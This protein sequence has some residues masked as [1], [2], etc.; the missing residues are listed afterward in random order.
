MIDSRPEKRRSLRKTFFRRYLFFTLI[1]LAIV[2]VVVLLQY[3]KT[4]ESQIQDR[5]KAHSREVEALFAKEQGESEKFVAFSVADKKI[6]YYLTSLKSEDLKSTLR[7]KISEYA[8]KRIMAYTH[9]GQVF[10]NY[11]EGF[12]SVHGARGLPGSL[13]AE[14]ENLKQLSRVKFVRK[15]G[16]TFLNLSVI[17]AVPGLQGK[18][19]GYIEANMPLNKKRLDEIAAQT[20][21]EVFLF[22][23][24]GKV[25]VG[26][27]PIQDIEKAN[28][29]QRFLQGKNQYFE[30]AIGDTPYAL[31]ATALTWGNRQFLVGMGVDTRESQSRI[32]N[33][34]I[35]IALAFGCILLFSFIMSLFF[36]REFISPVEKITQAMDEMK[37]SRKVVYVQN[38]SQTELGE[39]VQNFNE[40]SLTIHESDSELKKQVKLLEKANN[41]I[42]RAQ[43]QLVQS[44]KL[45]SLGELV[46]GIAH[47]LNNPI[48]FIYS[49][50]EH[51]KS[52]SK[53]LIDV[54]DV[55]A[56]SGSI[57]PKFLEDIDFSYIK[58][59]LP[60]L[61][62]SCE[63]G[64]IRAKDIVIGLRNFSRME[65]GFR[66]GFDVNEGVESTLKLLKGVIS[67][68]VTIH[69]NFSELPKIY[70][71]GNQLKQVFMNIINNGIQ[72][73][74][75]GGSL[76]IV[77][78]VSMDQKS[79]EIQIIDN[80]AGIPEHIKEKI[81]DPF[82]TTKEVGEGT[83][84]GLS[85][86]YGIIQSHNG[87]LEVYSKVDE[88]SEFLI[89]LPIHGD[90]EG[91]IV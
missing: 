25:L 20:G 8:Q 22:N 65:D 55:A 68:S 26:T 52:Y 16:E 63:E 28:L 77:T 32:R 27:L 83:G 72:A 89:R 56:Q 29:G 17:E 75:G 71:N 70:A 23:K 73:L 6:I 91:E 53:S 36:L 80:G 13:M 38:D 4:I 58:E 12:R 31:A 42:K 78:D 81:F 64:A 37:K 86:S 82:F 47:E 45:A 54:L 30:D 67:S 33:V 62:R 18:T 79:V 50:M 3:K 34:S 21:A 41:K 44:A 61:V 7:G 1:P 2:A 66:E 9:G 88:G 11:N 14:L 69:K 84:L 24:S 48:G 90:N 57:E 46:A 5:L 60:K 19:V 51:L 59:D 74:P 15:A 87:E 43:G 35:V 85:I 40:M 49:N 39:L 76:K 10:I